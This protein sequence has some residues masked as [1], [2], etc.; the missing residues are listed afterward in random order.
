[1][2]RVTPRSLLS[3]PATGTRETAP[4]A[5]AISGWYQVMRDRTVVARVLESSQGGQLD[6][7]GGPSA[8]A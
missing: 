1:M 3:M 6:G 4:P 2:R 8:E 5:W 7:Q